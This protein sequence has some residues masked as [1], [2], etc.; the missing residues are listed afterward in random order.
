MGQLVEVTF[1][2]VRVEVVEHWQYH[3]VNGASK[4]KGTAESFH[5]ACNEPQ[6][7]SKSRSRFPLATL[8]KN[9]S[10]SPTS[11]NAE[12]ETRPPTEPVYKLDVYTW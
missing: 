2:I 3:I 6:L 10:T 12:D 11:S 7:S 1:G 4:E 9:P 8:Q 5:H